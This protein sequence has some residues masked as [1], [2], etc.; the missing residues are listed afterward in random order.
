MKRL[1]VLAA[2]AMLIACNAPVPALGKVCDVTAP[3]YHAVGDGATVNTK[4]L[5]AAI[6][7]CAGT[8]ASP[9]TVLLPGNGNGN[10]NTTTA[11]VS[12]ALFLRSHVVLEIATG[13]AL[14]ASATLKDNATWPW[15]YK[16]IAGFMQFGH[17]SLLNGGVCQK[18]RPAC[19]D[20]C[21]GRNLGDTCAE[22]SKLQNVALRGGGT[23]DGDGESWHHPP[24][25]DVRPVLLNLMWIDGLAIEDLLIT[26][27]PFWT[28]HPV[29]CN[30]VVLRNT[31]VDTVGYANGDGIDVD[32]CSNT[33]IENC[34]FATGDDCIALKSGMDSDGRAVG[35]PTVNVTVRD[36]VFLEGHGCSIGSDMS[37]GVANAVFSDLRFEGTGAGVRI[38]DQRGRGGYVRNITYRNAVMK[39]VGAVL[40]ITQFYHSGIPPTNSSAT[41]TFEDF[42]VQNI[43]A[44]E[45]ECGIVLCLPE[46]PCHGIRFEN[47]H[48]SGSKSGFNVANVYGTTQ[49]VAPPLKLLSGT[50]PPIPPA[51]PGPA[52]LADLAVFTSGTEGYNTF[53]I[54]AIVQTRQEGVVLAFAEGRKLSSADHGWNDIVMKRST[55]NAH[56]WSNLSIVHGESSAENHVVIGNPAPI[57]D[58]AS[59]RVHMI[60]SRNN[61][62]VGVLHSDDHGI[63]WS[64]VTELTDTLMKP[65]NLTT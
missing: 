36:T 45:S 38:K 19:P 58:M 64:K 10:G 42:L 24:Y 31:T 30:N 15:I 47:V 27:P 22:W 33:L 51:M 52:G 50:P 16:R 4:A 13:A 40:E 32:S 56:T 57:V 26:R 2:G 54:P 43:T 5:Q 18:M 7:D 21:P 55:D 11:F 59:G 29:F 1:R 49:D 41:P 3:P 6:D 44:T 8:A 23:I 61:A 35:I 25:V 34:T 28:I 39:K 17:A 14:R 9:G 63:T 60:F 62:E 53:R 46:W 12:G 20:G 37:G 48:V 65:N